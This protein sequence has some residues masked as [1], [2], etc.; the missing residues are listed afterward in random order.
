MKV[1]KIYV[2]AS[3][4]F[5][6]ACSTE[7]STDLNFTFTN[8][9]LLPHTPA[10]NQG[11]TQTCWAYT[12]ASMLESDYLSRSDDTIRLSVMYA[13]R[14][15]YMKQFDQYYYSKGH[16]E[17]RG[18][19]LGHSFLWVL[20]EKGAMPDEAYKGY[21]PGVK[22][23]DHRVLLKALRA[24]AE[25]AVDERNLHTYRNKAEA[26]LDECMGPVP[27]RFVFEGK[28]YTPRSF[29][30][31]FGF[32]SDDYVELT[33]FTHHPFGRPFILEV[34]DN[35]EH[36]SFHN[37]PI[38]SLETCVRSALCSGHTVAWDGDTS[39]KGFLARS[40]V[41]IYAD[42]L[43][44]QQ[45]RQEGFELFETTDDHMMH[46]VGTAYD[47]EGKL[48]YVLKN[49]WGR[50]GPYEGLIYMSQEYFR[51]KTISVVLF[52]NDKME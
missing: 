51:A 36:A 47:K 27:E 44:S 10:R 19:G 31:S 17:I 23:H 5:L 14:Q 4:F 48:Y 30:D 32:V 50:I 7:K 22:Y 13:V 18:G 6:P 9:T 25:E 40:G 11:R 15:K 33:S 42:T 41:A 46:I 24:L 26:L 45:E 35:W 29:A 34:P 37:I 49:S 43:V 39:E 8:E 2:F 12:M 28:E 20:R 16:D 21:L 38:D 1:L 3:V 52:R